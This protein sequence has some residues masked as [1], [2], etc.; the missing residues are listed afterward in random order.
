MSN[1]LTHHGLEISEAL[2]FGIGAGLFFG[3]LPFIRLNHLPLITYRAATGRIMTRTAK[4]LGV[5]MVWQKFR[6]PRQ[7]MDQLDRQLGVHIPMGCRTGAYWLTYFPKRYRFH[8]NMHNLVVYGRRN[9]DYLI[10][11][12][13]FPEPVTIPAANLMKA[14]FA[15]GPLPPKG[16]MYRIDRIS[17][18]A[19]LPQ[20]IT[21]GIRQACR[22]M[23]KS[24]GPF[25]GI[26]GMRYLASQ[27]EKWP[28]KLGEHR[29]SHY[30][31]QVIR[32]QEEIGTGGGGFR[33]IYAAFLQESATILGNPRLE[34]ATQRMTAIG[35]RWRDFALMGSR[36]CK[37]RASENETYPAMAAIIRDCAA[38]EE[39][40]YR[41]LLEMIA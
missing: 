13:V 29:A 19:D 32:M 21:R 11:D 33:F 39:Q 36:I 41:D 26:K 18:D 24:P 28:A 31:G 7:G 3:Y 6:S 30:V 5:R 22:T 2:V 38:R 12:P 10:S 14:R 35:D 40:L 1:L 20:A 17:R 27:I 8:F 25:L 34:E 16:R 9:G 15:K 23:L 4:E 37:H